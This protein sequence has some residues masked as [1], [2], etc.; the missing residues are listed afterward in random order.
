[1]TSTVQ[2]ML[3]SAICAMAVPLAFVS[4]A[5]GRQVNKRSATGML[6][7]VD[8]VGKLKPKE[9]I[10]TVSVRSIKDAEIEVF[11]QVFCFDAQLVLHRKT[12]TLKGKEHVAGRLRRPRGKGLDCSTS[13]MVRVKSR[14]ASP[15]G[16]PLPPIRVTAVLRAFKR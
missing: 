13:A 5:D 6:P 9:R 10:A 11:F 14:P 2:R 12:K 7:G 1:M 8:P 4:T 15:S 3:V 16:G